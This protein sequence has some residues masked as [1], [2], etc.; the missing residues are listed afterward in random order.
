MV[1]TKQI[2]CQKFVTIENGWTVLYVKF[3]KALYECL[4]SA[5]LFYETLVLDLKFRGFI[6]NP[7]DPCVSNM[8]IN[9]NQMTITWHAYDL[10]ILHIDTYEV[11][12]Y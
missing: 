11:K 7:Y 1:N 8:M 6:I 5:L 2:I 3:Q 9:R 12:K 4:R 10:K